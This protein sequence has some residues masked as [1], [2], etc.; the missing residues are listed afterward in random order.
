MILTQKVISITIDQTI[1][2]IHL[3][4]INA[5]FFV[6][7]LQSGGIENYL[8]RFLQ[9]K[10]QQFAQITVYCKGGI[11]G[12]LESQYRAL[13]NVNI[14][15]KKIS[16]LNPLHY[17]Q[18][19]SFLQ[20]ENYDAVCD[21]TGNFAGPIVFCSKIAGIK[22]R[23]V[24]YRGSSDHFKAN[25]IKNL[26]ND[27]SKKLVLNYAT[28]ILSNSIA[29]LNFFFSQ[30]WK[31]DARFEVI[32]N[33]I[34]ASK[35][36]IGNENLR[37]CFGL[38]DKA[39]VVGHTGR[40]NEAKNHA[41]IIKVAELLSLSYSDIF[42]I[43]CGNGVKSNLEQIIESKGLQNRVLLFENRSDIPLFLNTM[44]CYYFPST[45]EG[46]PN[47]L[48]EAM[49]MNIPIVASNI[50]P[51]KETVPEHLYSFL[52]PPLD[53]EQAAKKI[54][55]IYESQVTQNVREWTVLQYDSK[56]LFQ[57]FYKHF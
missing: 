2:K 57:Q 38:P 20:A 28:D 19:R 35:F 46:Q 48:I 31:D 53:A 56:K 44:D 30:Q 18:L 16:F 11:G 47:A 39:F 5:I 33:G 15:K 21:F 55:E 9:N 40:Y 26:Y 51:I 7:S 23:I 6:T 14:I 4:M 41:T 43:L 42:F 54:L 3:L 52:V 49:V 13:P 22:K 17:L 29:A 34:D 36:D 37:E 8:L 45:T 25:F 24:F 10:H 50:E 1:L 32:Y 27:L 12:Q